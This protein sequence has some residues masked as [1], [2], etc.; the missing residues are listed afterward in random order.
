MYQLYASTII[1]FGRSA[2][3]V[4]IEDLLL[5][6]Y[7]REIFFVPIYFDNFLCFMKHFWMSQV[8]IL[9][10]A[11]EIQCGIYIFC[12]KIIGISAVIKV[13]YAIPNLT[14]D[15]VRCN[16]YIHRKSLLSSLQ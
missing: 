3:A 13:P 1:I 16:I 2:K 8:S 11:L 10:T 9:D 7:G 4:Q 5:K 14:I 15:M 12:T 6:L